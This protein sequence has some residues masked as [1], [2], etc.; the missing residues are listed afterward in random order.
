MK[1]FHFKPASLFRLLLL[2]SLANITIFAVPKTAQAQAVEET[3]NKDDLQI[4]SSLPWGIK[5]WPYS[6]VVEVIDLGTVA[7]RIVIDRYGIDESFSP[8]KQPFSRIKPGK[9]VFATIWSNDFD[10][11]YLETIVQAAP[12]KENRSQSNFTLTILKIGIDGERIM[13][14]TPRETNPEIISYRYSYLGDDNSQQEA[15]WHMNH[16]IFDLNSEQAQVLANA[17]IEDLSA[18]MYFGNKTLPLEI[19]AD[20]VERW[21]DIYSFN[22]SCAPLP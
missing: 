22:P 14:L 16:R 21:Q 11:C 3:L 7:G 8:I 4:D 19:G 13:E 9:T 1:F 5:K 2:A 6:K 18:R 10:G 15:I 17:P 20:T 12:K